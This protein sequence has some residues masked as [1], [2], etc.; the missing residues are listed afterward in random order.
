[1]T[2]KTDLGKFAAYDAR[3]FAPPGH[4]ED[5]WTCK[6]QVQQFYHRKVFNSMNE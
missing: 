4:D 1:M 5:E 2:Y 3:I 6:T